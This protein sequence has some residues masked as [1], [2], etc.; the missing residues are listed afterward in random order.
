M[1][2]PKIIQGVVENSPLQDPTTCFP[3]VVPHET[4]NT[5]AI[6]IIY[7]LIL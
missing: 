1:G 6:Y 4:T 5:Y 3:P 2:D 7:I